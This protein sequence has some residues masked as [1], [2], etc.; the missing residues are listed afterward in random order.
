[1][2]DQALHGTG[3]LLSI[4]NA[5]AIT[6]MS[7]MQLFLDSYTAILGYLWS[8]CTSFA[9]SQITNFQITNFQITVLALIHPNLT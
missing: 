3:G 9:P 7:P 5:A 2:N 1:M 8:V 6:T 4:Y